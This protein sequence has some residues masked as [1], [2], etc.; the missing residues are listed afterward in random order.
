MGPIRAAVAAARGVIALH[1]HRRIVAI[2]LGLLL[3]VQAATFLAIRHG[4]EANARR[5]IDAGM[6]TGEALLRRLLAQNAQQLREAARLL[7]ADY[8]FRAAIAVD[9]ASTLTDA[10]QNQAERIGADV[11][12]FTDPRGRP[13]AATMADSRQVLSMLSADAKSDPATRGDTGLQDHEGRAYQMVTVPVKAP[14]LIGQVSMGFPLAA[15]LPADLRTLSSLGVVLLARAPNAR[16]R[17]LAIGGTPTPGDALRAVI[18]GDAGVGVAEIDGESTALHLVPLGRNGE[19]EIAALLTRSIDAAVAPYREL[20][21]VLVV[22]TLA[23]VLVFAAGTFF[24]AR[25][26]TRPINALAESAGRLA[27]GDYASP[28]PPAGAD[29]VGHLARSFESMRVGIR[30]RDAEI[31]RLAYWDSLTGLPNREQF[32]QLVKDR[33]VFAQRSGDPCSVLMLDIDRFKQV[34]DVLGHGF[35]DRLLAAIATRLQGGVLRD[36]DTLARLGGDKFVVCMPRSNI[37]A[38]MALAERLCAL[39]QMPITLDEHT[40]DVSAGVGI[41]SF[42]EHAG[43]ADL[44]IGRAELAMYS[45]KAKQSGVTV[46]HSAL[47]SSSEASLSLLGELRTA[48]DEGQL[49]LFLQPKFSLETGD[50]SGAEALVR[51][52]HPRRGLLGPGEFIPFAERSGFI[53]E[54][55]GWM[56]ERSAAHY[57]RLRDR[58]LDLKIAVNLSTR[59]LMDLRLADKLERTLA[60]AGLEPSALGLEITESAMMDDPERA[61][62]TLQR[63]DAMGHTLSVDDFGTGYSSLAYLKRLP[64]HQ[65]K[66]DRSFVMGMETDRADLKI[67]RS[68]IDLAHN[69]GYSVVAEGVETAQT[70]AILRALK[71]EEAQGFF[72][73]KPMFEDDFGT[74]FNQWRK[75]QA[76]LRTEFAELI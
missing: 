10:L 69:L 11:A 56:V 31:R 60:R 8:G 33:L 68:T 30:E 73:A 5:D 27:S 24:T 35:G 41:A 76:R 39:L 57:G 23:G 21:I 32:R 28:V 66:I 52:Q 70:W 67:V 71:C 54:I 61:L 12:V 42:P 65:L 6:K 37:E 34:N 44:L 14:M 20:Q 45:A 58:G 26:I 25:R 18:D 13:V 63:L 59:D 40:V 49:R 2:F 53:R 75:P 4:I 43:T 7:A 51:W 74:W 15:S 16:W 36:G 48:I 29:E 19:R 9:D 47:D 22:I 1:L 55:T 38:A 46:Y 64:L 17:P 50:A 3:L 62:A 72:M